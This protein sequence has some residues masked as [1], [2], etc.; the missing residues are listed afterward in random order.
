MPIHV[1]CPGCGRRLQAP[2]RLAGQRVKCPGCS[3]VIHV[4]SP[5]AAA[6]EAGPT[7]LVTCGCQKQF[8]V[9]RELAGRRRKCPA[10][11]QVITIPHPEAA[12]SA[13]EPQLE[14]LLA[15]EMTDP[16]PPTS[17]LAPLK[18]KKKKRG[19]NT[20]L[21]IGLGAGV[22]LVVLLLL[23]ILLWPEGDDGQVA[24][25]GT[26]AAKPGTG[27]SS[28]ASTAGERK[29]QNYPALP[30]AV[31][32]PPAWL[33][34]DAPF[35][36][37]AYFRAPPPDENAAPLYLDAFYEFTDDM[38][39]CFSKEE[40]A[41]RSPVAKRRSK[42]FDRIYRAWE[43]DP[44]SVDPAE[45]DAI[46][47]EFN[48][49]FEKL[50]LAQQRKQCVFQ[51]GITIAALLPYGQAARTVCHVLA[52]RSS[53]NLARGNVDQALDNLATLLRLSRDVR[54]RGMAV[55]LL[56]SAALEQQVSREVIPELL[57]SARLTPAHC[58]QLTTMLIEQDRAGDAY[59]EALRGEYVCA[60]SFLHDLEH[61]TGLFDPQA[62]DRKEDSTR[63]ILDGF[64]EKG[65]TDFLLK[66]PRQKARSQVSTLNEWYRSIARLS[67]ASWKERVE[68]AEQILK[69]YVRKRRLIATM[70]PAYEAIAHAIARTEAIRRGTLCLVALRR[71]QLDKGTPPPDLETVCRA[72]G[73]K[74]VP[75][76]PY[77]DG[78]FRMTTVDG[79]PVV[80][81]VGPDRKDD[82]ARSEWNLDPE[83]PQ[84]DLV[85]RL[86]EVK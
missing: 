67:N 13:A 63:Q 60:L 1:E 59:L 50:A 12:H 51:P 9:R 37:A 2:D 81:S 11:G 45:T 41:R 79:R 48:T 28:E 75:K 17:P 27:G 49:G 42:R 23:V 10:C 84:G 76:D 40:R 53:R 86:P 35:D 46:L 8:Q 14:Q 82:G 15:A 31:T 61:R 38:E 32:E 34:K 73:M 74:D 66:L 7:I 64:F 39:D 18:K 24:D 30:D 57:A 77:G 21:I 78:P 36:V 16:A 6:V 62:I 69:G 26:A 33:V 56:I 22:G 54:R 43:K 71:W 72:A 68:T 5:A 70:L 65:W 85:F 29:E 52:M 20:G 3:A 4:S 58:D 44:K 83:A 25:S 47:G 19:T 55:C 80:Y